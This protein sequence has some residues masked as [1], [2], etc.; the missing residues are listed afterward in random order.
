MRAAKMRK[1]DR[2]I[3]GLWPG[4]TVVDFD[5]GLNKAINRVREVLGDDADNPRFIETLPQRGYRFLAQVEKAPSEVPSLSR[6][7]RRRLL[8]IAGGLVSVPLFAVGYRLVPS[9]QR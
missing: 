2:C 1:L 9:R 5:R 7:P 6:I 3:E 8:A 4:G